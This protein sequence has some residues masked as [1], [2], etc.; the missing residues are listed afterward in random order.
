MNALKAQANLN[1][2]A[3]PFDELERK[4]LASVKDGSI[5][6]AYLPVREPKKNITPAQMA[7]PVTRAVAAQYEGWPYPAWT[8]ITV[9]AHARLP[10]VIHAMDS[11][12][13]KLLP[14]KAN[15]LIAGCGTGRQPASFA[16]CY[17]DASVTAIDVS[18]ASL[19]Y[20]RRQCATLGVPDLRFVK[21]DLHD[22]ADLNQRFHAIACGGVLH[23]LSDPER[24]LKL[25]ADVLEPGGVMRI[26]VYNRYERLMVRGA[27]AFLISDLLQEPVTDD[28]LRRV[29]SGSCSSPTIRRQRT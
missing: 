29:A 10:D 14:V 21:L 5:I 16:L 13:A 19:D 15:V 8:R 1:G 9:P 17:P 24:G 11:D 25:L 22:V 27:R 26:M 23:H 7:D 3:W 4:S 6:A 20:A 28:L 18:E 12:L 2:G